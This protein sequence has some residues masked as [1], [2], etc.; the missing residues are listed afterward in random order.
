[1]F[2]HRKYNPKSWRTFL[3][4]LDVSINLNICQGYMF[5]GKH[6]SVL[7]FKDV[8]AVIDNEGENYVYKRIDVKAFNLEYEL[9][10]YRVS[11]KPF[12][13]FIQKHPEMFI[14]NM[15][16]EALNGIRTSRKRRL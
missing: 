16:R 10:K 12:E 6:T 2:K 5:V 13:L 8:M 15:T 9:R 3:D 4:R 14:V 11:R 7:Y 1:M